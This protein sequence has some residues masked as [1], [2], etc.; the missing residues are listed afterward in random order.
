MTEP[1]ANRE[2]GAGDSLGQAAKYC[3][4]MHPIKMSF[5]SRINDYSISNRIRIPE[6]RLTMKLHVKV[7]VSHKKIAFFFFHRLIPPTGNMGGRKRVRSDKTDMPN[8]LESDL[9]LLSPTF[10]PVEGEV[11]NREG[12]QIGDLPLFTLFGLLSFFS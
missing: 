10:F 9:D 2:Y 7:R 12:S 6:P 1:G 11:A 8:F 4:V 5:D 3:R